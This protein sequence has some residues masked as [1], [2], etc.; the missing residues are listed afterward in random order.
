[1]Y[2]AEI[3]GGFCLPKGPMWGM[4]S[5]VRNDFRVM[6]GGLPKTQQYREHGNGGEMPGLDARLKIQGAPFCLFLS[7]E[8][9][10]MESR[11]CTAQ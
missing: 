5:T 9:T 3:L 1:M 8:E 4:R 10:R 6:V 11:T 7:A 2:L